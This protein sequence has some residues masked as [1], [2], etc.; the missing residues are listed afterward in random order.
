MCMC[1][2]YVY[3]VCSFVFDLMVNTPFDLMVN[4]PQ[5]IST[6][7]FIHSYCITLRPLQL[8]SVLS[9]VSTVFFL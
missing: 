8:L 4:A 2:T 5:R 9:S 3:Y 6:Q 7:T 1:I